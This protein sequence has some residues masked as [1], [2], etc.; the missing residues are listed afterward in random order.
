M[1]T[2]NESDGFDEEVLRALSVAEL[3]ELS[4]AILAELKRR[5]VIR[6][7]NAPAGDYAELLVQ[8]AT[9]GELAPTSQKSWPRATAA[10]ALSRDSDPR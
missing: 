6:S 9:G 3:L 8:R 1:T 2:Q 4:R 7:G 10:A 5:G